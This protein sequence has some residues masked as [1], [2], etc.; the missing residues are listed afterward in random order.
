MTEA[1]KAITGQASDA[2]PTSYCTRFG[3]FM[4]RSYEAIKGAYN[5]IGEKAST[6]CVARRVGWFVGGLLLFAV[7]AFV[8]FV[9]AYG[10]SHPGT[11]WEGAAAGTLLPAVLACIGLGFSFKIILSA[12]RFS[13]VHNP[14]VPH[15]NEGG[16]EL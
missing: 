10:W 5:G 8:V 2:Q 6:H 3:T 12:L 16:G 14:A 7:C 15:V 4:S 1:S 11:D 13:A 9:Q